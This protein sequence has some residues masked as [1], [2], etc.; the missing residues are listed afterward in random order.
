MKTLAV[1]H[2]NCSSYRKMALRRSW[3][4]ALLFIKAG[5]S[6]VRKKCSRKFV[7]SL[8]ER[9]LTKLRI[10]IAKNWLNRYKFQLFS[11][12]RGPHC[13]TDIPG[14]RLEIIKGFPESAGSHR[15][16]KVHWRAQ[17]SGS[18]VTFIQIYRRKFLN[19]CPRI[20]VFSL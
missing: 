4:E 5:L 20:S 8:A 12:S 10:T 13:P 9:K 14:Q 2:Q 18:P 11:F 16:R 19:I 7:S 1:L 15:R 17:A 6:P 3:K